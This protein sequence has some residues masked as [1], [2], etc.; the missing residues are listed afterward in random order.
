MLEVIIVIFCRRNTRQEVHAILTFSAWWD[1]FFVL[2]SF[3][4]YQINQEWNISFQ[5]VAHI[6]K[7][8]CTRNHPVQDKRLSLSQY[9]LTASNNENQLNF[10]QV[11]NIKHGNWTDKMNWMICSDV[12]LPSMLFTS[13]IQHTWTQWTSIRHY[14]SIRSLRRDIDI[15]KYSD[16]IIT[17]INKQP[18]YH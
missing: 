17:L 6:E 2:S 13:H 18:N 9:Y 3:S 12:S 15:I 4:N 5:N 10:L 16:N 7:Y 11:S 8:C 1:G 14:F